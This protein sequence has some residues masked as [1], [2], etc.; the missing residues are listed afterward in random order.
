MVLA[1]CAA[2]APAGKGLARIRAAGVLRWGADTQGGEPYVYDDPAKPGH[3]IGFEVELAAAIARELGVRAEMVQNDWSNLV[4]SLERG[5]FDVVMNGLEVTEGRVGRVLFSRPYYVFAERLMARSEDAA[6]LR[7]RVPDLAA[8]KGR[9]VGTLSNSLA[10]E[11]LRGTAETVLYEGVEEPY[12]DLLGGRT[13]AVLLDDIIAT[14]YGV[15]KKGLEVVGDL[16]DG[17]YALAIRPSEPE[18]KEA[19]DAALDRIAASGELRTILDGSHI[20]NAR[21]E[22]LAS[23]SV[24]DQ[25][26]MLGQPPPPPV[27]GPGH[28]VLFVKGAVITLFVSAFAMAIAVAL[29]MFL[30][31]VRMYGG[32]VSRRVAGAYVEIYRGT[33]VLLQLYLL[34]YGLAPVLK[35][36]PLTAAILGLGMNYAAYE[37]EV[38]RAGMQA[39]PKTQM[40]A[41]L[42]LGMSR[43]LAL[44]R[45]VM[46]Q[47]IRHA[48]PNVTNDFIALLKD[49]SLVSVITVVELTKQMTITA[50]DVRTWIGPGLTCAALYFAMSYP[51]GLLARRL[52]K[53]LEGERDEAD[54]EP[55]PAP[56][57]SR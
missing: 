55:L 42:S 50:V 21:Q 16:R 40:E 7:G 32:P 37:A 44:R 35:L 5:T 19:I 54:A 49:S 25:A 8:L 47:A 45:V 13:D 23:W 12:T 15:P 51:L 24:A 53:K 18:V 43:G 17:Y 11:M 26:K 38:Y 2:P 52:E 6:K 31:L 10:F 33:P 48:I 56:T 36:G 39:V 3:S 46:P 27:F 20:W 22:R 28:V 57:V 34:Y 1:G 41:A 9:R 30:S 14:R 4:P 29:G